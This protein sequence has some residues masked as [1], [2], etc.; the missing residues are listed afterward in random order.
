M[1]S[2]LDIFVSGGEAEKFW[3]DICMD[4]MFDIKSNKGIIIIRIVIESVE[5]LYYCTKFLSRYL[6]KHGKSESC[7]YDFCFLNT[8]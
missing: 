2:N 5:L 7:P 3:H 6:K 4:Y 8:N 1:F